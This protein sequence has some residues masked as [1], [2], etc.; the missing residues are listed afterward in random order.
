[1][2]HIPIFAYSFASTLKLK[3]LVPLF[4][5]GEARVEK[6]RVLATLGSGPTDHVRKVMAYDSG[7]LVFV[8]VEG[9]DCEKYVAAV[10]TKLTGAP[11]PPSSVSFAL[12]GR[13]A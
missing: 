1:M 5:A 11:H 10:A 8:G 6:D 13:P 2:P 7:A 9:A 3:D 4:A 12:D